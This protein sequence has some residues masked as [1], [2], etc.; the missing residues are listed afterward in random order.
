MKLMLGTC[1]DVNNHVLTVMLPLHEI[2]HKVL[3]FNVEYDVHRHFSM[4][5]LLPKDIHDITKGYRE[6]AAQLAEMI[7]DRK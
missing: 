5:H 1:Y 6:H 2:K 4:W 7:A 3:T